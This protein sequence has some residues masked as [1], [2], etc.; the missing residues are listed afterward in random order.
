MARRHDTAFEKMVRIGEKRLVPILGILSGA[1]H[2]CNLSLIIISSRI[3]CFIDSKSI[4][5]LPFRIG[6]FQ[7][8]LRPGRKI[9]SF[10]S[11][12]SVLSGIPDGDNSRLG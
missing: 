1:V 9:Q 4:P 3:D 2:P 12:T 10:E 8:I 11:E 7:H 5:I 6:R